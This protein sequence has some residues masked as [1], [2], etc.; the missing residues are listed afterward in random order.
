MVDETRW[1]S[2]KA[3]AIRSGDDAE[4]SGAENAAARIDALV[5]YLQTLQVK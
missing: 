3:A 4:S 2:L 1:D 5:T